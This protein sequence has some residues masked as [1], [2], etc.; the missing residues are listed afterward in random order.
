MTQVEDFIGT[1]HVIAA[2]DAPL[3]RQKEAVREV[4]GRMLREAQ[5][6]LGGDQNRVRSWIVNL[7]L[8]LT[9]HPLQPRTDRFA[10]LLD[11]ARALVAGWLREN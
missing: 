1:L 10:D 3:D 4:L 9:R 6:M 7:K 11:H 5:Q 8:E 2:S